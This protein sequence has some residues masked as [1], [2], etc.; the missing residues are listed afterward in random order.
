[1]LDHDTGLASSCLDAPQRALKV[2]R[3]MA[4]IG[5]ALPDLL[6]ALIL[7]CDGLFSEGLERHTITLK[8][9]S[10]G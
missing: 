1:M 4:S 2:L 7:N 8:K 9:G 6:K 3:N 5:S 10:D